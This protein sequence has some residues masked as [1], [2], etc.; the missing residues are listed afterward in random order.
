MKIGV[1]EKGLRNMHA[2]DPEDEFA[3]TV[4]T[5]RY[6]CPFC[7]AEFPSWPVSGIQTAD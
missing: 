6:H 3:F 5:R 2:K 7:L 4:G 1:S